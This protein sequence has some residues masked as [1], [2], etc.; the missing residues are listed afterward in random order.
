MRKIVFLIGLLSVVMIQAQTIK[1]GDVFWDGRYRYEAVKVNPEVGA[2]HLVGEDEF[3]TIG[4]TFDLLLDNKDGQYFITGEGERPFQRAEA[5]WEVN[6][7]RQSGMYF[8]AVSNPQKR[9]VSTLV[10]TP[11]NLQDLT[12]QEQEAEYNEDIDFMLENF[13]MN[14]QYLGRFSLDE[15][16]GMQAK[17][18]AKTKRSI[19][20]ETNL[21]LIIS[22]QNVPEINRREPISY[23]RMALSAGEYDYDEADMF[24][25]DNAAD[26][27]KALGSNRIINIAED[28]EINLSEYLENEALFQEPGRDWI[29]DMY[30]Y[31]SDN[32]KIVSEEVYDGR[33]LTLYK[34]RN[35]NI[36]GK[37]G[38]SIVV[39][40]RYANV[41]NLKDCYNITIQNLVMGHTDGSIC[42]GGVIRVENS[43]VVYLD[44][45]DLYGCGTYGVIGMNSSFLTMYSCLIH[46]C[47][48]G[49]MDLNYCKNFSFRDCDFYDNDNGVWGYLSTDTKFNSCHFF[50]NG[51]ALFYVDRK[52]MLDNCEMWHPEA[53][54]G[55]VNVL[56]FEELDYFWD[57]ERGDG[58]QVREDIGPRRP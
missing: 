20:E 23:L 10:L 22:E 11:D 43:E 16:K 33:Q 47:S 3:G 51:G 35:L 25:V 34:V 39:N 9:I 32:E 17:L 42:S 14:I 56:S 28:T 46:D 44:R 24:E 41:F 45:C 19:I 29:Y 2:V 36:I 12:N 15:L 48:E 58:V 13:L 1:V 54:R 18:E 4:N 31:Q 37:P 27:I 30:E 49:I 38:S 7:I 53:D 26:F 8:L 55:N 6:Y 40:P 5:G 21:Q 50:R 52:V 57:D